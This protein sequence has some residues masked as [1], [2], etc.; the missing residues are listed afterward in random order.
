MHNLLIKNEKRKKKTWNK[1]STLY[2]ADAAVALFNSALYTT[3][4]QKFEA[5]KWR[6]AL[7]IIEVC[8]FDLGWTTA[9]ENCQFVKIF[10]MVVLY[11][12]Q[13]TMTSIN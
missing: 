1:P 3:A 6:L 8:H 7:A 10:N 13:L 4:E 12:T 2:A 9:G 5:C 11:K